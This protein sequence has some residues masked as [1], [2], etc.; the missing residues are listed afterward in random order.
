M[1][2]SSGYTIPSLGTD[3]EYVSALASQAN[4][5][6][7]DSDYRKAPEDPF[8]AGPQDAMD[9]VNY[10]LAHPLIYD[11]SNIFLSGFSAGGALALGVALTLGPERIKGVFGIYPPVD[12]TR[13]YPAPVSRFDGGYVVSR[14][15]GSHFDN[16]YALP[17][18]SH[19]DPL[20]SCL[21][22]D[23]E[24]HKFPKHV[25]L[26]C[27]N[28]DSLY[29]P[30]EKLAQKMKEAGVE[31]VVFN[32][33][34][35]EAHGFDKAAKAGSVSWERKNMMYRDIVDMVKKCIEM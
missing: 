16:A 24:L 18:Q 22:F 3:H 7:L 9:V 6:V 30:V 23:P 4:V 33:V 32:C 12:I 19:A 25:Y 20:I 28:A 21:H 1:I 35:F 8:P 11:A 13:R 29:T 14:W 31:D 15:M 26:A 34:E 10:V 27:G 17:A 2:C 5:I